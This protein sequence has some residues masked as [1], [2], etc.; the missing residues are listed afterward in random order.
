ML[1]RIGAWSRACGRA[2][3]ARHRPGARSGRPQGPSRVSCGGTPASSPSGAPTRSTPP[4]RGLS[5]NPSAR[6]WWS[7]WA[8]MGSIVQIITGPSRQAHLAASSQSHRQ[9]W[10][11][12]SAESG[13]V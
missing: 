4:V 1:P 12:G 9:R 13:C 10:V 2:G 3:G 7:I 11:L 5:A 8:D 6:R